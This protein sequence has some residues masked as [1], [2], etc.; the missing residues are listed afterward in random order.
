MAVAV[1]ETQGHDF[2]HGTDER[3][4]RRQ[5]RVGPRWRWLPW[6]DVVDEDD[7]V[8][9]AALSAGDG[10]T[11]GSASSGDGH[12]DGQTIRGICSRTSQVRG[13]RS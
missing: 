4:D 6:D 1:S 11:L 7:S 9:T 8:I 5:F 3:D 10:Y 2:G 13:P 12:G